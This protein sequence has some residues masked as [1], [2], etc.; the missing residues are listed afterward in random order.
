VFGCHGPHHSSCANGVF[1]PAQAI[2]PEMR[3]EF[4]AAQTT[5]P[6]TASRLMQRKKAKSA[7]D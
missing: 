2:S 5:L 1:A 7:N 6:E 4:D 3:V